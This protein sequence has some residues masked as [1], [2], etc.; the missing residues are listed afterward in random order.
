MVCDIKIT[1]LC[2]YDI[3]AISLPLAILLASLM[4]FG[5]L[6]ETYQLSAMKAAG[7][8]L[9]KIMMPLVVLSVIISVSAFY[10]S[11]NILPIANLKFRSILYDI[12]SQKPAFN[13][14][15]GI[16]IMVL[17]DIL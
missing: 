13:I 17:M 14:K 10:F 8:S 3:C 5:N 2:C 16:F 15:Q 9:K 1:F 12:K 7:I 4:T 6:G 11:N